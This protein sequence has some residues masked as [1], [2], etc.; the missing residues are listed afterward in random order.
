MTTFAK[1]IVEI[2]ISLGSNWG[3]ECQLSQIY[4][5]ATDEAR[6]AIERWVNDPKTNVSVRIL[7]EPKIQA[8]IVENKP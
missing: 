1:A 2:E 7:K 8:I 5:Q 3:N 6:G 4:K